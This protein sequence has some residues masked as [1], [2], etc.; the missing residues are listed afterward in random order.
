MV[1]PQKDASQADET[2]MARAIALASVVRR[3]VSPN[4]WVGSVIVALGAIIGEG[5]TSSPGGP[6]AEIHALKQAGEAARG[7]TCYVT[8]EPCC[9]LGRTG[10]CVDALIS[11]GIARVVI[12]ITDP[13]EKVAG[14]GIEA[15]RS[16]GIEVSVGISRETVEDQLAP[17]LKH[18]RTGRPYVVL[19]LAMTLDGR[20]AAPDG[21][22]EFIT[23]I[24]ARNDAHE[25]RADSDAI[26]IGAQTVRSDDP[27][28]TVRVENDQASSKTPVPEPLR[29]VLG[30]APKGAR[31]L[32]ALELQ[33]D[34]GDIL[35]ELGRRGVLQVLVEGGA[36]VA[37]DFHRALLVDH[38]VFYL[39]PA[40]FGG[41]DALAVFAGSGAGSLSQIFRGTITKIAR[42]GGDLRVDLDPM[43]P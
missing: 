39:A 17:Y 29:V 7:A 36:H 37:H 10:S 4:P 31:V 43:R 9:H 24:A 5:A 2:N 1:H 11:S 6:H 16:A 34:L 41:D 35:D 14:R 25:L 8:L 19:K 12:A 23:G 21:T 30:R 3:K 26:L 13:D 18:R 27:L 15:L 22:S 20:I 32:P 40:L 38:Y 42:L 33:G 28:L